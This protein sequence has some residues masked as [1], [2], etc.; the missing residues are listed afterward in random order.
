MINRLLLQKETPDLAI[1]SSLNSLRLLDTLEV[2]CGLTRDERLAQTGAD[3]HVV[4]Q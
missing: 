1:G 4:I 3:Y 2:C